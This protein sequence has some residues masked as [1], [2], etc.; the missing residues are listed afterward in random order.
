MSYESDQINLIVNTD[1]IPVFKSSNIQLWPIFCMFGGFQPFLVAVYSGEKKPND[2][3]SFLDDF[4]Q[5]YELLEKNQ[6]DFQHNRYTVNI[7]AF[8]Y[9]GPARQFLKSIKSHNA[10]YGCE[11]YLVRGRWEERVAFVDINCSLRRNQS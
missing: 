2:V 5:D 10:Y 8:V 1:G 6:F 3:K 4:L 9:D 7:T 11:R